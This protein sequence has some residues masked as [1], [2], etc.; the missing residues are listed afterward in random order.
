MPRLDLNKATERDLANYVM[1]LGPARASRVTKYRNAHGDILTPDDLASALSISPR[2]KLFATI[3]NQVI[4]IPSV[5]PWRPSVTTRAVHWCLFVASVA[6]LLVLGL[7]AIESTPQAIAVAMNRKS[8]GLSGN[9]KFLLSLVAISTEITWLSSWSLL[10]LILTS[11][12]LTY[13]SKKSAGRIV[14]LWKTTLFW[15]SSL[16]LLFCFRYYEL[17]A[18]AVLVPFPGTP[19]PTSGF[20]HGLAGSLSHI[21]RPVEAAT[22]ILTPVLIL[23]AA[24]WPSIVR[25]PNWLAAINLFASCSLLYWMAAILQ[26]ILPIVYSVGRSSVRVLIHATG[27]SSPNGFV[28]L[29]GIRL[30]LR[31]S[32][33]YCWVF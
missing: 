32:G 18:G 31:E 16:I 2:S 15:C 3:R 5:S 25:R 24:V 33:G 10:C 21:W 17:V 9:F 28:D 4:L 13:P 30:F 8:S 11:T 23:A 26:D 29:K 27:E 12:L 7:L 20:S 14:F 22:Y 19:N 6:Q 1:Q